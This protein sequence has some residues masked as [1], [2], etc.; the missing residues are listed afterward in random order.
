VLRSRSCASRGRSPPTF[1]YPPPYVAN[2]YKPPSAEVLPAKIPWV[3]WVLGVLSGLVAFYFTDALLIVPANRL[4]AHRT[5]L[6]GATDVVAMWLLAAMML[7]GSSV[8]GV[9]CARL[10]PRPWWIA[11]AI[12]GAIEAFMVG[13]SY[14][15][16]GPHVAFAAVVAVDV[17]AGS[18]GAAWIQQRLSAPRSG[19]KGTGA[20]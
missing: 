2:P 20:D 1:A 10:S 8:G 11:P 12:A 5:V 15:S 6:R 4:M 19:D 3:R 7:V 9:V 17:I 16:R 18:L 14:A 13:T